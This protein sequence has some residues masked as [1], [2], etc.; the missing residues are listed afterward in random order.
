MLEVHIKGD[1]T[2]IQK[3]QL[4]TTGSVYT[5]ARGVGVYTSARGVGG[6][7]VSRLAVNWVR[8]NCRCNRHATL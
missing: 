3:E 5:S 1:N 8:G 6:W 2:Y 4:A 7:C